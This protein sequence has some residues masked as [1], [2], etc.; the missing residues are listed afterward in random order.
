MF[1]KRERSQVMRTIER[2]M[3][4]VVSIILSKHLNDVEKECRTANPK[5]PGQCKHLHIPPDKIDAHGMVQ[6]G[7]GSGFIVNERGII[8]TNKHVIAE[9]DV[10]YTV[11]T[12]N[13]ERFPADVIARDPVNDIAILSIA[14]E[15]KLPIVPVGES[16]RLHLGQT[17]LAFG[18]ALGIFQNTVSQGI[19]SGLSRSVVAQT[20]P[21]APPQEMR[22]LIQTDAAINPGNSGGPLTDLFGN[23]IGINAA[24]ISGAQ[25]IGFAIPI[26]PARRDL[27]DLATYGRIRRPLLGLRYIMI[28]R[29]LQEKL[30]LP[31][32]RGALVTREHPI[33]TA[34]I[35]GT[36]A[37][38]ARLKERDIILTWNDRVLTPQCSIL[39]CLEESTVGEQVR[40]SLLRNEK[41]MTAEVILAERK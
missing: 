9:P 7:G 36:P 10:S 23:V 8:L 30:R 27:H 19:I 38:K 22:G 21:D 28:T 4:A 14:S 6:V 37:A 25:N 41:E 1:F 17:V 40:L 24:V 32:D 18:N 11:I 5:N 39:D 26:D 12:S 3:P 13:E 16:Q 34:V 29:D 31:V 15:Q 20:E 2:T 33:D 35:P